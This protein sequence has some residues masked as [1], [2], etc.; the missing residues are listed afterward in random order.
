MSNVAVLPE[1]KPFALFSDEEAVFYPDLARV[2]EATGRRFEYIDKST[3]RDGGLEKFSTLIVPGG[4]TLKLL[5]NLN[6]RSRQII[7]RFVEE[8]GGYLGVCMG[9]YLASE[10]GLV[11]S[12]VIRV[13]GE[14][15]VELIVVRPTH[16]VMRGYSGSVRMSYQNGPE[17]VVSNPDIALAVFLNGRAAIIASSLGDGKVVLFSSHPERSRSNWKM[18]ENALDYLAKEPPVNR[19]FPLESE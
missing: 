12:S 18:I 17:I 7:S 6:G 3:L 4:Y 13:S 11:R 2:L 10:I 15:I 5:E 8:G 19:E 16:P 9:T 1:R 14:F